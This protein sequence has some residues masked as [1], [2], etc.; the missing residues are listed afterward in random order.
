ML[1]DSSLAGFT[2]GGE[3]VL[4]EWLVYE[5]T[6]S[7]MGVGSL[8]AIHFLPLVLVGLTA[9]A[10]ADRIDRRVLLRGIDLTLAIIFSIFA[11]IIVFGRIELWHVYSLTF[12]SGTAFAL[13]YAMR[14]TYAYDLTGG[15]RVV[16]SLGLMHVGWRLGEFAG[17]LA[18]G[19]A[20]ARLGADVACALLA[21]APFLAYF[22]LRGLRTPGVSTEAQ[23][24]S[25]RENLRDYVQEV[26]RNRALMALVLITVG[27]EIFAFSYW[28]ALPE[29]AMRR[30]GMDAEGLGI[31]HSFRALGGLAVGA[32]LASIHLRRRGKA[33]LGVIYAFG[34]GLIALAA[35]PT[36]LPCIAAVFW[37]AGL[38]SAIDVLNQSMFQSCV[39]DRLR[40]RAM[41]IWSF[42]IGATTLGHLQMGLLAST[43]GAGTALTVNGTALLGVATLI[44]FAVPRLRKL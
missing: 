5:I 29:I 37:L 39:P 31:L 8:H 16:S 2:M 26:R 1:V 27:V 25:M 36:L 23:P 44:L 18:I 33:F 28:T 30:L 32:A 4:E 15:D 21:A 17:A 20:V 40:G 43:L 7:S 14:A 19:A 11:A 3:F 34:A 9:G 12:A 24:D 38:E 42:A 10:I 6:G 35:A 13:N 22:V 41:G